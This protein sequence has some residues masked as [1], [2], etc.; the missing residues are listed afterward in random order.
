[1]IITSLF[2][3]CLFNFLRYGKLTPL[4][5]KKKKW[6]MFDKIIYIWY[7]KRRKV[8]FVSLILKYIYIKEP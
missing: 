2:K 4:I 6:R 5:Q 1:M 8:G 3:F 7:I